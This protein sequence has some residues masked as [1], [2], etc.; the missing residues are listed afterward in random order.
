MLKNWGKN[1]R[2][3]DDKEMEGKRPSF[4][5]ILGNRQRQTRLSL[6]ASLWAKALEIVA[7]KEKR[8]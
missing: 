1:G 4:V 3:E 8:T 6:W 5:K 2:L 7:Q